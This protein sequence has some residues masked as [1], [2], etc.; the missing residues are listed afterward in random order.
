M[1]TPPSTQ[2]D[3][4][5]AVGEKAA[6]LVE[7]GMLVGLGTGSTAA[8]FIESLIKRCQEGLNITAVSSSNRSLDMA[9]KGGI[10]VISMDK[11]TMV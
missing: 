4:K 6:S 7:E 8:F 5:R 9:E 10:P 1:K 3:L 11:V 2:D